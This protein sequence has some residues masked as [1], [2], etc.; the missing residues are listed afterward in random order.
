SIFAKFQAM[1]SHVPVNFVP[2][3]SEERSDNGK[4]DIFDS[5]HGNFAHRGETGETRPAKK[6]EQK[7]LDQIVGVM[8]E[9]NRLTAPLLRR[10]R[11]ERIT[12]FTRGGFDRHLSVVS[13]RA[14]IRR[15]YFKIDIVFR[16]EFFDKARI[17]PG[18]PAA[19][20][21]VE[22]ADDQ[23]AVIDIDNRIQQ[24]DRVAPAGNP[25]EI[26][27]TGRESAQQIYLCLNPIHGA[28]ASNV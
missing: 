19:Q 22:M 3:N 2:P 25:D 5:A 6:I 28:A 15:S 18:R 23:L 20:L 12:R 27:R 21:M 26:A 13:D 4:I 24:H 9:K 11:K 10:F 17:G 14:D 1:L 7:R 16:G 8:S